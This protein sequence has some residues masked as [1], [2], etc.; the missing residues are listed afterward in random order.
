MRS[1]I[2]ISPS[3]AS[4]MLNRKNSNV[5]S[6]ASI[7]TKE[8]GLRRDATSKTTSMIAQ[9]AQNLLVENGVIKSNDPMIT[10][11][12]LD[13]DSDDEVLMTEEPEIS[14]ITG[15]VILLDQIGLCKYLITRDS[16]NSICTYN[17]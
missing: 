8:Q 4:R 5:E 1:S 6:L 13:P 11:N 3:H 14:D 2:K 15:A 9:F 12:H 16:S 7:I 10:K 17:F